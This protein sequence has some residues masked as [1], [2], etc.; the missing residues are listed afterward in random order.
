MVENS[1]ADR[2]WRIEDRFAI[3]DLAV[4]YGFVM[5]ERDLA[6]VRRLFA[7]DATL[8]SADGVFAANGIDEIVDTYAGRFAALGPTNHFTHGHVVRFDDADRDRATGLL[9]SH[10]EVV[11]DDTPM[12][13]ALRY[14]DVYRRTSVGWQFQDRLMSYMYY[15]PV[16]EYA[17]GLGDPLRVRAYGDHRQAD[18]PESLTD[19]PDLGW[20]TS[21]LA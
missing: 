2:I 8:R 9:A 11:R 13:V 1:L 21:L 10:A 16:Q 7:A 3:Q 5:D 20:L 4:L 19:K 6:G 14:Q 15:L 17:D 18:W 12:L